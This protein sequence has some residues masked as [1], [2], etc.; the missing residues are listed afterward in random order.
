MTSGEMEM[1]NNL[2]LEN[3]YF[4]REVDTDYSIL[5]MKC[6]KRKNK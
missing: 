5:M 1:I 3:L 4:F 6:K 2:E